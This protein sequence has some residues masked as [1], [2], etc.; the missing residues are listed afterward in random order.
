MDI[1]EPLFL[2]VTHDCW[3]ECKCKGIKGSDAHRK[4]PQKKK[5]FQTSTRWALLLHYHL[6][7]SNKKNTLYFKITVDTDNSLRSLRA[8]RALH[9]LFICRVGGGVKTGW[10]TS[11]GLLKLLS[12][13]FC[14]LCNEVALCWYTWWN[15]PSHLRPTFP[16][17]E[18][19]DHERRVNPRG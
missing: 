17:G 4:W 18:S 12:P 14:I 7:F 3:R 15:S 10:R 6:L 13:L 9:N 5:A 19:P 16:G 2:R 1:Y 11:V 8:L